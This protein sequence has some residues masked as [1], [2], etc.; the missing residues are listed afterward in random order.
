M[1]QLFNVPNHKIDTRNFSNLL[2]DRVVRVFE[3]RF[4][5]YVGARYAVSF[6]SATAA[7]FLA[8]LGKCQHVSIPSIIPPVVPTAVKNA[9]NMIQFTDDVNWV[10]D[11]YVLHRFS[12]YWLID[13][14]H[15]VARGQFSEAEDNDL[16]VFSFYPT[17]VVS[18]CDG[19]IIVSNDKCKIE[20]LRKLSFNGMT[21]DENNWD[22]KQSALGY[23]MYMNSIQA[24]IALENLKN[25]ED[26]K[27]ALQLIRERYNKSFGLN[28]TSEHLYRIRAKDNKAFVAKA[29]EWGIICGIH[30]EAV[31][32][33]L[34]YK[35][36]DL[37]LPHSDVVAR[38]TV[39]IPYH[40]GLLM[41]QVEK[42]IKFVNEY[43]EI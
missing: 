39:S 21:Q 36:Q 43:K 15:R 7:I 18:G 13:S 26:K 19:G 22:R 2:H 33:N 3:E 10:G 35:N 9:G 11:S 29:R 28:N 14:A 31:H 23:K 5:D 16:M 25:I 20:E 27:E 17:K 37:I 30:Y 38:E 24:Y 34:L 8:M 42:V 1:I 6:S 4:A 12:D 41:C 32:H 40:E